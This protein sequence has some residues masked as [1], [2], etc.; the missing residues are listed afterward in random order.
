MLREVGLVVALAIET[1]DATFTPENGD[2]SNGEEGAVRDCPT[3]GMN[4][5]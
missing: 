4:L 2:D 5:S 1:K 3:E